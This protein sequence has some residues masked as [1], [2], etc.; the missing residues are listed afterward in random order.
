MKLVLHGSI[1]RIKH[2]QEHTNKE[3]IVDRVKR[4]KNMRTMFDSSQD[5]LTKMD[6]HRES[7]LLF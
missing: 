5:I 2:L 7:L 1:D 6:K 3:R 4:A